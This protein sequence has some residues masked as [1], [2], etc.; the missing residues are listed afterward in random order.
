[1]IKNAGISGGLAPQEDAEQMPTMFI[2]VESIEESIWE[3]G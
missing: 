2:T 1:M 3:E